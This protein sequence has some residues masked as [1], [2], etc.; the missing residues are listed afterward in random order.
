M[1][2]AASY[3]LAILQRIQV[4]L[5]AASRVLAQFT[6]G[7]VEVQYKS[8]SD[9]VTAADRAVNEEIRS[10][11]VRDREAGSPRKRWMI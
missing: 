6:P 5:D 11:L 3:E 10:V 2:D 1:S 4:A 8:G 9:P 7:V